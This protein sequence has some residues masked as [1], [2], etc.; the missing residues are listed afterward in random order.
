MTLDLRVQQLV[1]R[2]RH[3]GATRMDGVPALG[4]HTNAI[5]AGLGFEPVEIERLRAEQAI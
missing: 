3:I 2:F 1:A 4:Q 5:L